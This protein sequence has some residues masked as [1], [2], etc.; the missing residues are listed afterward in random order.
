ME[1]D[2]LMQRFT[3]TSRSGSKA[4]AKF[5]PVDPPHSTSHDLG[6]RSYDVLP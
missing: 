5:V 4:E 1:R 6:C 2:N 3:T